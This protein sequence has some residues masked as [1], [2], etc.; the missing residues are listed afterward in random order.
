MSSM[1]RPSDTTVTE[2]DMKRI[3]NSNRFAGHRVALVVQTSASFSERDKTK[4]E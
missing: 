3:L 2:Q 4:H 1:T